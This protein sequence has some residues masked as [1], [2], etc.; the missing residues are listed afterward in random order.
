MQLH[1]LKSVNDLQLARADYA[2]DKKLYKE[3]VIAD[4]RWLQT[5]TNYH[6]FVSH[7]NE[8]RQLLQISGVTDADIK[9][10]EKPSS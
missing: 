5:K 8:T 10:L 2:R 1:H 9:A 6:V 3:G 7:L 4:R